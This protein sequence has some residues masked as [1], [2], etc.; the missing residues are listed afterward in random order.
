LEAL[1]EDLRL[2]R[3]D[4]R[5]FISKAVAS[6]LTV[7]AASALATD[8]MAQS[9]VPVPPELPQLVREFENNLVELIRN[10]GGGRSPQSKPITKYQSVTIDKADT[11]NIE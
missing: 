4:R 11:V 3:T 8:A 6:G 9:V 5:A 2:G 10:R 1:V 7:A